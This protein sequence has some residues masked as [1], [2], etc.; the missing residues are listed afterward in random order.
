[1]RN[2]SSVNAVSRLVESEKWEYVVVFI[3]AAEA[4]EA[5]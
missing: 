5:R 4:E 2:A 3:T 1:M